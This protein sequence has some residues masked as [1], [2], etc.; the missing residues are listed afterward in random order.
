MTKHADLTPI[1][2]DQYDQIRKFELHQKGWGRTTM[3]F[4]SSIVK[5]GRRLRFYCIVGHKPLSVRDYGQAIADE[6]GLQE[7]VHFFYERAKDI[8]GHYTALTFRGTWGLAPRANTIELSKRTVLVVKETWS[9]TY[10][11]SSVEVHYTDLPLLD[12][13]KQYAHERI[14]KGRENPYIDRDMRECGDSVGYN[15]GD[16]TSWHFVGNGNIKRA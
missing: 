10:F 14:H 11:G 7:G 9:D 12:F 3:F 16:E 13:A 1:T 2:K 4:K 15:Y 8:D 6:M 5:A